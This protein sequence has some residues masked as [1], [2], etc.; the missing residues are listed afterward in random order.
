MISLTDLPNIGPGLAQQL[1]EVGIAS[2]EDL[3]QAGAKE[4]WLRI[5]ARDPSA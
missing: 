5:F 1:A 4:T 3:R 2:P